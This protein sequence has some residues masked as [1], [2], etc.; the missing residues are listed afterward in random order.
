MSTWTGPAPYVRADP[1]ALEQVIANLLD[2]AVKYSGPIKEITVRVRAE[3]SMAIV[4]IADR[5][6]GVPAA[7]QAR[8]FERFYRAPSA[9]ASAGVRPGPADRA[10]AR[11]RARRAGRR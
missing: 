1:A 8:I 2:N 3:R 9:V 11:A 7:D 6:V 4:E 10:R 5:G